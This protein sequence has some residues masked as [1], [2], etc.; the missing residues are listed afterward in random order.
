MDKKIAGGLIV[1]GLAISTVM[2]FFVIP[3]LLQS[4]QAAQRGASY[5]FVFDFMQRQPLTTEKW[6]FIIASSNKFYESDI[7]TD[8]VTG[9]PNFTVNPIPEWNFVQVS[10]TPTGL[11]DQID[12]YPDVGCL[13][14]TSSESN[15]HGYWEKKFNDN[16]ILFKDMGYTLEFW[17]KWNGPIGSSAYFGINWTDNVDSP[18]QFKWEGFLTNNSIAGWTKFIIH[19]QCPAFAENAPGGFLIVFGWN[20]TSSGA[21]S[22]LKIDTYRMN[23]TVT[24]DNPSG[25]PAQNAADGFVAQAIQAYWA[26]KNHS[27]DDD[28]IFLMINAGDTDVRVWNPTTN[29][30]LYTA[31]FIDVNGTDVNKSRFIKELNAS[32]INSFASNI[33]TNDE[34]ILYMSDHGS[35][36]NPDGNASFH[37]DTGGNVTEFELDAL[38]D[39]INCKQ[40]ILMFDMCFAGNYIQPVLNSG[41]NRVLIGSSAP[42]KLS[43]YWIKSTANHYAGSF[44]F[45]PFWDTLN[46]TGK[47]LNDA[48]VAGR[49]HI[50]FNHP[51]PVQIIQGPL[52]P[53]ISYIDNLGIFNSYTL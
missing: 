50:P 48:F 34:L 26:L 18:S 30:F 42:P 5:A 51:Q 37:F 22:G 27:Y 36:T 7:T 17:A 35:N 24:I 14:I 10:G 29:D 32:I 4:G 3:F 33:K 12:G 40:M 19:S 38:L 28:H 47:T 2:G 23:L 1:G 11:W 8:Y 41:S 39:T 16:T 15:E 46:Q 21:D 52:G 20:Q 9:N 49:N 45:H 25:T 43:W 6:A 13:N 53:G 31:P 44:F